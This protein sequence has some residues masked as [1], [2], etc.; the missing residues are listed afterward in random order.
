LLAGRRREN[1]KPPIFEYLTVKFTRFILL[2]EVVSSAASG[3][4]GALFTFNGVR[5]PVS[6]KFDV[7]SPWKDPDKINYPLS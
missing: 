4:Y 1:I 5:T 2:C 6:G 3:I 7:K